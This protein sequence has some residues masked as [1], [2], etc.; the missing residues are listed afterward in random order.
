LR[1][2]GKYADVAASEGNC[3]RGE[4]LTGPNATDKSKN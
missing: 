4:K 3:G 1:R 2:K